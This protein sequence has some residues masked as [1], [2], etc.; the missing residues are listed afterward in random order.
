MSL[1]DASGLVFGITISSLICKLV[2]VVMWLQ[3]QARFAGLGFW[4]IGAV[5]QFTGFLM[6]VFGG[7]MPE[8]E[9][10]SHLHSIPEMFVEPV[11]CQFCRDEVQSHD[12]KDDKQE[13]QRHRCESQNTR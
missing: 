12:P 4:L 8:V 5:L 7:I 6:Q 10:E 3:N 2:I 9:L 1:L 13:G 11:F